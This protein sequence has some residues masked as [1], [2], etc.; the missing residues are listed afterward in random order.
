MVINPLAK[1]VYKRKKYIYI[2]F[3]ILFYQIEIRKIKII[4][5]TK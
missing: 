3:K 1:T 4:T 2:K 5:R